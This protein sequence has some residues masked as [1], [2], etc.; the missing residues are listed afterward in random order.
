MLLILAFLSGSPILFT[1]DDK[2]SGLT[3][4]VTDKLDFFVS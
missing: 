2:N 3:S 1:V 4:K